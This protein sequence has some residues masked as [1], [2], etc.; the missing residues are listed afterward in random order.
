M[1]E[2]VMGLKGV[3]VIL[4]KTSIKKGCKSKALVG[5]EQ[6]IILTQEIVIGYPIMKMRISGYM[7]E[8][9]RSCPATSPVIS[10]SK[11]EMIVETETSFYKMKIVN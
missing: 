10:F 1:Q 4:T 6:N 11:N 8:K 3:K 2:N 9:I 5:K 7:S